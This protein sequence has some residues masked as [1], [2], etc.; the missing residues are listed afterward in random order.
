MPDAYE[1]TQ[2][3][4]SAGAAQAALARVEQFQPSSP[5]E[6]RWADWEQLRCALLHRLDRHR[7]LMQRAAALPPN[8]PERVA[9]VCLL[10]GA[11]AASAVAQGAAARDFLARLIWSALLSADDM[12]LA[13]LLVI[14]SY[15]AENHAQDA[16]KLMLRY[17]Q[18]FKPLDSETAARF[19]AALLVAGM[20]KEA[21]NWLS[22]LDD[23]SPVK[24]QLRLK[25]NLV[26]PEA[27]IA[28]ARAAMAKPGS[29][30]ANWTVLQHAAVLQNNRVL[31][32]EAL[33]HLLQLA[34][35]KAPG[36]LA[37][38]DGLWKAYAAAAQEV[39]NQHQLLLGDEATWADFAARRL[40]S[41][42]PTARAFFASLALQGKVRS[43]REAAQLQ[44]VH[45]LQSRGLALAALRLFSD[46][47]RFPP[48]ELD[49]HARFLLGTIAAESN[50]PAAAAHYWLGLNPPPTL[51]AD[52]W[53][54]RLAQVLVRAG[55]A[56]PG[57]EVLR[58][59]IAGR[60]SLPAS[61]MQRAVAAVQELQDSGHDRSADALYRALL[62]LA[63]PSERR[64]ILFGLGK[65]AESS[66][67]FRRAADHFLEAALLLEARAPDAFML[68]A[69]LQAAVNLGRAGLKDDA[70]AQLR[71]LQKNVRDVEK[72]ELIRREMQKL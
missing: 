14:E 10:H 23:A 63:E 55:A 59:L 61:R 64:E 18:D 15:L 72:L 24:L 57:A 36:N 3:F 29:A 52:E 2:R 32:V 58:A 17:E 54:L 67:D 12:R 47:A 21:V 19:V 70:R 7:E 8:A 37:A 6:Q 30:A 33:E 16:Y 53:R 9:R 39:A 13:R 46:T 5:A 66:D 60:K 22:R 25:N 34:E 31:H 26:T 43:T 41:S 51:E 45:A 42:P 49:A 27:A 11:R 50:Q 28:Q 65:T 38:A 56:G 4:A 35:D 48:A 40:A 20:E 62:P 68:N 44:L 1:I 71:W 69:R